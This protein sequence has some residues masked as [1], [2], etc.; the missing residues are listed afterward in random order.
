M[1]CA[2][3]EGGRFDGFVRCNQ[4]L[5]M[6]ATDGKSTDALHCFLCRMNRW[7]AFDD[8]F[9]VLL[10]PRVYV[11]RVAWKEGGATNQ[12]QEKWIIWGQL[13]KI[14]GEPD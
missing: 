4:A 13:G 12:A 3:D 8:W 6:A 10:A 9:A 14:L 5:P 7:E 11:H 1:H 2:G